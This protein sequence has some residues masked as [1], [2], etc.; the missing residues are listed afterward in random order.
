MQEKDILGHQFLMRENP[1]YKN[2]IENAQKIG[3]QFVEAWQQYLLLPF[4]ELNK[5]TN[6]K[7]IPYI[8]HGRLLRELEEKYPGMFSSEEI[9]VPESYHMHEAAHVIAE[10]FF[11]GIKFQTDQERIL[12]LI[13]C[14]AFANTVDAMACVYANSEEHQ[15]ALKFNCYMNPD[16]EDMEALERL[17]EDIGLPKTIELVFMSYVYSNFFKDN[18]ASSLSEDH[19]QVVQMSE[20]LDPQFRFQTTGMYL[21]MEGFNDDI[22][23]ILNFNFMDVYKSNQT[24]QQ[25]VEKM[26][27][28]LIPSSYGY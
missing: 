28:V 12:K 8:P 5:I 14:E 17:I 10:N 27:K 24:F 2:V 9:A 25:V 6:T 19:A 3:C 11:E 26:L 20:K 21:K 18:P 22:M 16:L 4:H 7:K 13:L 23:Q 1:V 15:I